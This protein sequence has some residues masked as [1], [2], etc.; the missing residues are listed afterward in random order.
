M[1]RCIFI[2]P[3]FPA[4]IPSMPFR[5]IAIGAIR[6]RRCLRRSWSR[7]RLDIGDCGSGKSGL[8]FGRR[9][10][11]DGFAI[12]ANILMP[13]GTIMGERLAYLPSAGFCLLV[14]AGME[15]AARSPEDGG[16][17]CADGRCRRLCHAYDGA[18]PGL[19]ATI[20]ALFRLASSVSP[21]SAKMHARL[22][23][24][25][26]RPTCGSDLAAG[27]DRNSVAHQCQTIPTP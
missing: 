8:D 12:T 22:R 6:C 23:R 7:R 3:N 16:A 19:A 5:F 20:C 21:G 9:D 11:F 17:G 2:R 24:R 13:T 15:L 14:G 10:L 27:G 4:T 25:N 26:T 1:W 18:Q